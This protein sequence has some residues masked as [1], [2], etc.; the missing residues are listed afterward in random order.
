MISYHDWL[1][2]ES[3]TTKMY[4]L[5]LKGPGIDPQTEKAIKAIGGLVT[6]PTSFL[7]VKFRGSKE[8]VAK[9]ENA[10]ASV[11]YKV[12]DSEIEHN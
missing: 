1:L 5:Y 4:E 7:V 2:Q 8:D 6:K 11:N 10:L 3:K 12:V 9:V